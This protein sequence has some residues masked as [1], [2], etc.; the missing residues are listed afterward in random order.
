MKNISTKQAIESRQAHLRLPNHDLS[1]AFVGGGFRTTTFLA[2]A[3]EALSRHR[4]DVFERNNLIGPGDYAKYDIV[5]SS[6]GSSLL[7]AVPTTGPFRSISSNPAVRKVWGADHPVRTVDLAQALVGIGRQVQDSL[8][9]NRVHTGSSVTSIDLS[10]HTTHIHLDS[11]DVLRA[12]HVVL[13]TGRSERLH[14]QLQHWRGKLWRSSEVIA[15]DMRV[16]LETMLQGMK[17]DG[18]IV[19]VGASHSAMASLQTLLAVRDSLRTQVPNYRGPR[20][21]VLHRNPARFM[22]ESRADAILEHVRE[23]EQSFTSTDICPETGI[24]FRDSGL[25]HQSKELYSELWSRLVPRARLTR[26]GSIGDAEAV[27][28]EANIVVQAL[29]YHGRVPDLYE[30]GLMIRGKHSPRRM[31]SDENGAAALAGHRTERLSV[32]RVEPTPPELR[33]GHAYGKRLYEKLATRLAGMN[34]SR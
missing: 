5:T 7:K 13:A 10:E 3:H 28:S 25:R 12:E 1:V 22:Y 17:K 24:V 29:G 20:F 2:F 27:L 32:L 23:R 9:P 8:G 30:S 18:L 26:I 6:A 21:E 34:G 15:I 16:K 31:Y 11:G 33:D 19:I 14:P 4:I